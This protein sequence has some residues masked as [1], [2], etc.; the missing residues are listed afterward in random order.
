MRLHREHGVNPTIPRCYFCGEDKNE[1]ALLGAAYKTQAPMRGLC[2]DRNP[3][4]KCEGYMK[5]GV[6][7]IEVRDGEKGDDPYRAGGWV[8][9]KDEAVKRMLGGGDLLAE[10]LKRRVAFIPTEAWNAL[11]LREAAANAPSG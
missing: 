5:M 1:V 10:I 6:I 4:D 8:V 2:L 9:I 11:G 3:C 7:L